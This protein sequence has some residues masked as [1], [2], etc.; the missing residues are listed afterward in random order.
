M[1][2]GVYTVAHRAFPETLRGS[3]RGGF[4]FGL[5]SRKQAR[6]SLQRTSGRLALLPVSRLLLAQSDGSWLTGRKPRDTEGEPHSDS[7]FST[8]KKETNERF[9]RK[10]DFKCGVLLLFVVFVAVLLPGL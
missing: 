6:L 7:T 3:L 2:L 9:D 1:H 4:S 8:K 10:L 5:Y